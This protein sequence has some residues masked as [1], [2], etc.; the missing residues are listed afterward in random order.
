MSSISL[1]LNKSETQVLDAMDKKIDPRFL[2]LGNKLVARYK[3]RIN[4]AIE[5]LIARG[6]IRLCSDSILRRV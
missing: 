6:I 5:S 4:K 3:K 1:K 2:N